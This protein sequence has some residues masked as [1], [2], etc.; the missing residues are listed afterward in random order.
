MAGA[1]GFLNFLVFPKA[2]LWVLV[3]V[4]L[5]PLLVVLLEE[6]SGVRSFAL[7]LGSGLIFFIGTCH[8]ISAVLQTYGGLSQIGS[9][10][11]FLLL[12]LHLSLFYGIFAWTIAKIS[13]TSSMVALAGAPALWVATEYLRA[14]VLTGFPW[15]LLGYGLVDAENLSQL[16][17]FCGVYG[18]SFLAMAINAA[19]AGF[20][21]RPSRRSAGILIG[22]IAC[23]AGLALGFDLKKV[24]RAPTFLARI[25]QT[26]IDL[27]QSWDH[28]SKFALLAQLEDLSHF[29][30]SQPARDS[31][32]LRLILWPETPA[33]FYF[34]HDIE[35]R[36]VTERIA[37]SN[38]AYFVCAFVDFRGPE[39]DPFNS[40]ALLSPAGQLISQYDKIHLVPFG[41]YVPYSDVFFFLK[42]ISTEAGNFRAGD[43][44]V[45]SRLEHDKMLGTFIC[46]EAVV[47]DLVRQFSRNGSQVF[48]NV[49]NDAWFGE[50][51]APFQHLLMARMR[52]IEN[53]RYLLRAANNGISAVIDPRGRV[54][55]FVARNQR[56]AFDAPFDFE[57]KMTIY[58]VWGD[59]FPL[60]CGITSGGLLGWN[61]ISVRR[62]VRRSRY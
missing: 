61:W 11:V 1:A 38:H 7:G 40:V 45:V 43:R 60:V 24:D 46:Y 59:W 44:V 33:P 42:K 10:L 5:A 8:W 49:T 3:W 37:S 32:G 23:T 62:A 51:A 27:N 55:S 18:L 36:T 35:F 16:G 2:S 20:I 31:K 14:H 56:T 29:Q 19:L 41:E 28:K 53:R 4:C 39:R 52:A 15:C 50:S 13:M 9:V 17:A 57:S 6:P 58:A 22:V 48:V 12:A 26:N 30:V 54:I 25:V 47:P 34:N 21:V